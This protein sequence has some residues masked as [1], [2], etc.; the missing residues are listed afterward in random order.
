MIQNTNKT[1]AIIEI[2]TNKAHARL[3][4]LSESWLL[5]ALVGLGQDHFLWWELH[6]GDQ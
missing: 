3:S 5:E 1:A 4:A 6:G 2:L